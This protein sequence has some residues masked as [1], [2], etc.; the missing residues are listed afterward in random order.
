MAVGRVLVMLLCFG[1]VSNPSVADIASAADKRL[2][3]FCMSASDHV[4]SAFV[5]P[6]KLANRASFQPAR[7]A[8]LLGQKLQSASRRLG[9]EGSVVLGLV[10]SDTGNL[11]YV[12]VIEPSEHAVLNQAAPDILRAGSFRPAL[13]GGRP[14]SSCSILRV[15]FGFGEWVR[16]T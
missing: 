1:A 13:L 16:G 11:I 6:T 14:V 9:F 5:D 15:R 10:V 8:V 12:E 3:A 4:Q 7:A 2:H